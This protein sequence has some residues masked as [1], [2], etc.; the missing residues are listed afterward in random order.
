[1]K[2]AAR[3]TFIIDPQRKVAKHYEHVD[4]KGHSQVV[5]K[6]LQALQLAQ[7]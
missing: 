5:L 6:N 2:L 4:P 1:M 3:E 7:R